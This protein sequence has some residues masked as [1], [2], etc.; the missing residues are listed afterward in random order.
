MLDNL[1]F[2]AWCHVTYYTYLVSCYNDLLFID[3]WK[4][5]IITTSLGST[6]V[7]QAFSC[8][9]SAVVI[10]ATNLAQTRGL[11]VFSCEYAVVQ[12]VATKIEECPNF[13]NATVC[14]RPKHNHSFVSIRLVLHHHQMAQIQLVGV[15]SKSND[16]KQLAVLSGKWLWL[17]WYSCHFQYQRSAVRIQSLANIYWSFVYLFTI[18]CIENRM[19]HFLTISCSRSPSSVIPGQPLPL[20]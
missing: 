5:F 11:V 10:S 19:T 2:L 20:D 15:R 4:I 3:T 8:S 7:L 14:C 12:C 1:E 6:L 13:C 17:S 9:W 18:N 16:F